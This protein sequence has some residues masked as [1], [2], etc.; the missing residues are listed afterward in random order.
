MTNI[1]G[2]LISDIF[3]FRDSS[4]LN[5]LISS[6]PFGNTLEAIAFYADTNDSVTNVMSFDRSNTENS[7][8]ARSTLS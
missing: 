7:I 6:L 2:F 5:V 1:K 8:G 4:Q 3:V